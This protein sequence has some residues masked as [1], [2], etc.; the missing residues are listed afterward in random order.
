ME[1]RFRRLDHSDEQKAQ[2]KQV[3]VASHEKLKP[4]FKALKANRDKLN[5][6]TKAGAFDAAAVS[7]IANEQGRLHAQMKSRR[8]RP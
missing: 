6:A 3:M 8:H 5:E 1:M 4:V 2:I 7:A